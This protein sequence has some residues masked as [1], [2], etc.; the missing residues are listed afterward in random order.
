MKL[1]VGLV[2]LG[3]QWNNR[4]RPALRALSDR[5]E[6]KAICCEVA[7]KSTQVAQEFQAVAYDGFR[8]MLENSEIDA[9]LALAPDWA[10]PMPILAA[11]EAGKAVY[12]AAALDILP[13]QVE[14]IRRRVDASGVA[15]MAE[16]PRRHA[17]ATLRLKELIATRLGRPTL[18]FCHE[19]LAAEQ[20]VDP[21]RRSGYCPVTWRNLMEL[22]DW[23][24]YLVDRSPTSVYSA[25]QNLNLNHG[26]SFYQMLCLEFASA[27]AEQ[28]PA[29]AQLSLGHYIPSNWPDALAYRRPAS[30][31]IVCERGVAFVD[32]PSTLIWFDEA[33][34]HTES[35]DFERPVGEQML[36]LFHRAV[37]S[38]VRRSS[39]LSDAWRAMAIVLASHR[40]IE[41]GKRIELSL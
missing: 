8:A 2:G 29:M 16:L 17:P 19:R 14:E 9:V 4:H 36:T 18:L 37:T 1:R 3:D 32:L 24:S 28:L 21:R 25:A 13:E 6:V 11:C 26:S 7:H 34:Q 31:Q 39:D 33:G 12:S 10:G 30:V 20:Q 40:S 23:C 35:L 15:F 41:S 27:S 5:F 38:L 22:V